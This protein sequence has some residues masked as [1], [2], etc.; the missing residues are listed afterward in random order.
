MGLTA[1]PYSAVL[2]LAANTLLG[3]NTEVK[4]NAKILTPSE[5]R[6]LL[7]VYDSTYI[8]GAL[9]LK[10]DLVG[11]LIPADQL[12]SYVDDVLEYSNLAAFPP[13]GEPGKIYVAID[14]GRT[15]RWSGSVYVEITDTTAAWGSI[16]GSISNQTDLTTFLSTTYTPQTRTVS[17]GTGLSGGGDLGSNRTFNLADTTVVANSYGSSSQV[18]TFT[19]DAQ[20]RLTA[21]ANATITP[22]S[23]GALGSL[24][25]LTGSAQTF[26][27]GTTGTDFN[28][29]S[30]GTTHTFNIPDASAT[31]RGL[32]TTGSQTIAGT[33]TFSSQV[34]VPNGSIVTPGL[35]FGTDTNTGLNSQGFDGHIRFSSNG[36]ETLALTPGVAAFYVLVRTHSA[37]L[38]LRG[39]IFNPTNVVEQI[40][41]INTQTF[42][43]YNS[44]TD[45]SNYERLALQFGTY[46]STRYAQIAAESAGTGAANMNLVLT[47]KG[48]GAFILGPPPDG[49]AVGGN[50]RGANA[51]DLQTVRS[52]GSS[53]ASGT[54]SFIGGGQ[55]NQVTGLNGGCLNGV[56]NSVTGQSA[57]CIGEGNQPS[58]RA[59]VSL[60]SSQASGNC[61]LSTGFRSLSNRPSQFAHSSGA[62]SGATGSCQF[63]LFVLGGKTT[64][65]SAV[66]LRM[67]SSS[68]VDGSGD[69]SSGNA[70]LLTIPSGKVLSA[71][72]LIKGIKSDGSIGARFRRTVDIKNV[73]GTT[74]LETTPETIG[75]DYNPLRCA[76]SII[77]DDTNDTLEISVTGVLNETWRWIAIVSGAEIAYGV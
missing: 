31:A 34:S 73:G 36:A 30:N 64:T 71:D 24:N 26:A 20:G 58:G 52:S 6:S 8:D 54:Q 61:A 72:V 17:A 32:I 67:S 77:A 29:V 33:K 53:V 42:R 3:N 35:C 7:S 40:N 69:F 59:S 44:F 27:T 37:G 19:V 14:S 43:V 12:P 50:A 55:N 39:P 2:D 9:S 4:S 5:V 68:S 51:V 70:K 16:S 48:T 13:I 41:S 60:N 28:I 75:T 63:S 65:N 46:S 25:G 47:P 62:F 10:A 56:N 22:S 66:S 21:A 11:G 49:T 18:A 23:I 57:G 76:L 15:Y 45:T 38:D 1:F 74:S